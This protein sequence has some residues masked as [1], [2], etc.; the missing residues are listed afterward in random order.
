M[1]RLET[2]LSTFVLALVLAS[3]G[4]AKP[5]S[6]PAPAGSSSAALAAPSAAP[7]GRTKLCTDGAHRPGD[8][9]KE[10]C[11]PCRC[12]ADGEITCARFPCAA[13]VVKSDAGDAGDA[14][15]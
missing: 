4:C 13:P 1:I 12:A 9:W 14:A 2:G 15:P 10:A 5:R 7:A 8:H 3:A 6:D 11:N